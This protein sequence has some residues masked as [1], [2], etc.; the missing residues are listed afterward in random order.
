MT[1][2][3]ERFGNAV[4]RDVSTECGVT[5]VGFVGRV[6]DG[7]AYKRTIWFHKL[8]HGT[9][10]RFIPRLFFESLIEAELNELIIP[11]FAPVQRLYVKF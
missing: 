3:A 6:S 10:S 1:F 8:M 4:L 7:K 9:C 5:E 11:N 2:I